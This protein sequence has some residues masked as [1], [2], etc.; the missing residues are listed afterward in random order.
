MNGAILAS[1]R[2]SDRP[3]YACVCGPYTVAWQLW[4]AEN[5]RALCLKEPK[6]AEIL[7]EK[8]WEF[9]VEYVD[10]YKRGGLSGVLIAEPLLVFCRKSLIGGS[11]QV[12]KKDCGAGA[13]FGLFGNLPFLRGVCGGYYR[14]NFKDPGMRVSFWR[15]V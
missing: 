10:A 1:E 4:G 2:I 6:E 9:Q 8:I 14:A 11:P 5:L 13:V 3:T 7:L 15:N 12:C